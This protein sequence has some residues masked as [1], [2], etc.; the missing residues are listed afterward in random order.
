MRKVDRRK[1]LVCLAAFLA[2]FT[3]AR[4]WA[5]P[6]KLD[7]GTADSPVAPGFVRV[8]ADQRYDAA[9]GFG[10]VEGPYTSFNTTGPSP[11]VNFV[12]PSSA[13]VYE[14]G[15]T[16]LNRDGLWS[17][18]D[19]VFRADLPNGKY[20]VWLTIGHMN[21]VLGS[22]QVY[23]NGKLIAKDIQVR[24]IRWRSGQDQGYGWFL[25]IRFTAD[26]EQGYL[27]IRLRGDDT[28]YQRLL[29]IENEKPRPVSYGTYPDHPEK[30]PR[31]YTLLTDIGLPFAG[32]SILGLEIYPYQQPP[33]LVAEDSLNI[34]MTGRLPSP[35]LQQAV[36]LFNAGRYAEACAAAEKIEDSHK[37]ERGI[38]YLALAG[39]PELDNERE[40]VKKAEADLAAVVTESPEDHA[41]KELLY[42]ARQLRDGV[43][44]FHHRGDAGVNGYSMVNMG[45]MSLAALQPEDPVYWKGQIYRARIF[46]MVQPHRWSWVSGAGMDILL[47]VEKKW[48]NN[49]FV[50]LYLDGEWEETEDWKIGDYVTGTEGAPDWAV[51][52]RDA[53]N[54]NL[55]H[56]EWW[57]DN[58]QR[59]DGSL[60]G[61]WGDDVEL[62]VD[63]ANYVFVSEGVRP[64]V[65][66]GVKNLV[67]GNWKYS[68]I[69][70]EAGFYWGIADVGHSAEPTA[71]TL[72]M[73]IFLDYG[74]PVYVERC[75]KSGKLM[76]DLWTA[77]NPNGHRHFRSDYLGAFGVKGGAVAND[78]WLNY[79][80]VVAAEK[81]LWYNSSPTLAKL[82]DEWATALLED[83]MKSGRGK[84]AGVMPSVVS[85]ADCTL[86]GVDSPTW[87]T[88]NNADGFNPGWGHNYS[89]P[90]GYPLSLLGGAYDRT[91]DA[92]FLEP[93]RIQ[94]ELALKAKASPVEKPEEG[95]FEWVC[96]GLLESG[97]PELW[98]FIQDRHLGSDPAG[99][100]FMTRED[101]R[102]EADWVRL[103]IKMR[104]PIDTT[105]ALVT[106]RVGF[107]GITNAV[108]VYTGGGVFVRQPIVNYVDIGKDF[109][110]FPL[111]A[112]RSHLR[113]LLY[114][115]YDE[116]REV[117]IRP[118]Q[119]ARGTKYRMAA[120]PDKDG[121]EIPDE[122]IQS[123]TFD[124]EHRGQ[125]VRF[126]L[127]PRTETVV[128]IEPA[129]EVA[130]G[131][132][133]LSPDPAIGV[134]DTEYW[135]DRNSLIVRVHNIGA[136]P[137][138]DLSLQAWEGTPEDGRLIGTSFI[139][140]IEAPNDLTA[141][142]VRVAFGWKPAE[143]SSNTVCVVLDPDDEIDEITTKNNRFVYELDLQSVSPAAAKPNEQQA[144]PSS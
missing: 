1:M 46:Y 92:R 62:I 64:I 38:I 66:E 98:E 4:S 106:D 10:F 37:Y 57:I 138:K 132:D 21:K 93:F 20:R 75:M 22:I 40:M 35:E 91:G 2:A 104:W 118:W 107:G 111:R 31:E 55:D 36:R 87:Y 100:R 34:A 133:T 129:A 72:P 97:A 15:V 43:E 84:P 29:A 49:R 33:V 109:A 6:L 141:Q 86:G 110:A 78:G 136:A 113:V 74:S 143:E 12:S 61:G 88:P 41:A 135:S 121:D 76:R 122:V 94:A 130:L 17:D 25:P 58:K 123:S 112:D 68:G 142:T 65:L 11:H 115:F 39:R 63:F 117:G 119:L 23:A 139:P 19:L 8:T 45:S 60:G 77:I 125:T 30:K 127:P 7:M 124:F 71:D 131:H 101:A 56:A 26:I 42:L 48:P 70:Q 51:A 14:E 53:W 27:E 102:E 24:H 13:T 140:Y 54:L 50:K 89:N 3:A 79:R 85:F 9:K 80:A 28:E 144:Q 83:T 134:G 44:R 120:G 82:F 137:V 116:E 90:A 108:R 126:R 105:E 67:E 32:N 69:D 5:A 73:M 99:A 96:A 81:V 59:P 95:S 114:S 16:D 128:V 103:R 18:G 47:E 52:C